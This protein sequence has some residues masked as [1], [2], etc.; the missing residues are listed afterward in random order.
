MVSLGTIVWDDSSEL[1]SE[2]QLNRSGPADLVKGIEA[3]VRATGAE[4][5][6]QHLR[7]SSELRAGQLADGCA[8]IGSIENVEKLRPEAQ[9]NLRCQLKKTLQGKIDLEGAKPAQHVPA[10]VALLSLGRCTE[11]GGVENLA[12]GVFGTEQ[13]ER[14][15]GIH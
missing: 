7:R 8:E 14:H 15:T 3:A 9:M 4:T 6:R 5:S 12:S 2:P 10:K 13:L 1:E 11:R